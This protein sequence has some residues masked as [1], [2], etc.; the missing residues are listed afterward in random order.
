[1]LVEALTKPL[2]VNL[3]QDGGEVLLRPG[4]PVDLPPKVAWKL[5]RQ[6]KGRV[7]LAL[8]LTADW[9]TL[10]QFVADVS[11]GLE[12]DDP[13]LLTVLAAIQGCDAAFSQDN[14]AA[15]LVAVE[16]VMAA[17][18]ASGEKNLELF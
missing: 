7:R 6:A 17:M 1:M 4:T 3:P 14:R 18:E 11:S 13:R 9:L 5:L 10:W 16:E 2:R 8:P 12:P 15:F